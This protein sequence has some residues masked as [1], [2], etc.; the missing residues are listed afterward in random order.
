MVE[1]LSDAST[2]IFVVS[3]YMAEP[4]NHYLGGRRTLT[5]LHSSETRQSPESGIRTIRTSVLSESPFLLLY[6]RPFDG[7]PQGRILDELESKAALQLIEE[8]PGI[9]VYRGMGW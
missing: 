4:I 8:V 9:Q 3:G 7:D 1:R 5:P 6:S 2:P